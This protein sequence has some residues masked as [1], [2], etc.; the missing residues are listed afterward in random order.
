MI[1]PDILARSSAWIAG[2]LRAHRGKRWPHKWAWV[3][4]CLA[5]ILFG[6]SIALF[7]TQ[8]EAALQYTTIDKFIPKVVVTKWDA[9]WR[10]HPQAREEKKQ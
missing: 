6:A 7:W 1:G 9:W 10:V 3:W 5:F 4:S 2:Y 8:F